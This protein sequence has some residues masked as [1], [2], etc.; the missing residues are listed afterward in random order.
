MKTVAIFPRPKDDSINV[1][2]LP[3]LLLLVLVG[4]PHLRITRWHVRRATVCSDSV[5][6][7]YPSRL[8]SPAAELA[9]ELHCGDGIS[10]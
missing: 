2:I 7:H 9:V 5:L 6:I 10:T 3:F 8:G 1:P 4:V